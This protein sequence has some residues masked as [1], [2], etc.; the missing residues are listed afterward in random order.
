MQSGRDA[1]SFTAVVDA[2]L[3]GGHL[4]Q[5][6]SVPVSAAAVQN[7]TLRLR[8]ELERLALLG[9]EDDGATY[10]PFAD[11]YRLTVDEAVARAAVVRLADAGQQVWHLLFN[12]PRAPEGLR[13]LAAGLR[14][15]PHGSSVQVV[16]ESQQFIVPWAL[17]YDAPGEISAET[18]DWGG[19]WGYRYVLDVLPPGDYPDPTIDELSPAVRLLFHDA[20]ELRRYTEEQERFVRGVAGPERV[21]AARGTA[22]VRRALRE[23]AVMDTALL[24]VY[25]H[26]QHESGAARLGALPSESALAF[27]GEERVRLADMRRIVGGRLAGRP[28]VF[29]NA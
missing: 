2:E 13:R 1:E 12:A 5:I 28:L 10:H 25:C 22:E 16:I 4:H 6:Y 18:L 14:E 9:V 19:F 17:L 3:P 8:Q 15:L 21:Q 11:P 29:L 27:G 7:A 26:G 23:G 24:Y 20:A